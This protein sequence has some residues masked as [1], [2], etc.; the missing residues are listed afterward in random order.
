MHVPV[1]HAIG[2]ATAPEKRFICACKVLFGNYIAKCTLI[3]LFAL[4]GDI[5]QAWER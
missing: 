3:T 5:M 4:A 1:S 2:Y